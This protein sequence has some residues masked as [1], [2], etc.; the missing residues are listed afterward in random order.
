MPNISP[1]TSRAANGLGVAL[2]L[3]TSLSNPV[4]ASIAAGVGL[5]GLVD[6]IGQGRKSA[7]KFTQN[8]GPQDI[9][10]KQ[11]AAISSSNAS[12]EEKAQATEKAW[13]DF[14]QAANQFAAANPKQSTVVQQAIYK[15]P[16]LT[17]TVKT[18]MGGKDPLDPNYTNMAAS[19][20]ATGA[21]G[22]NPGPSFG[23]T[24]LNSAISAGEV[25]ATDYLRDKF[26]GPSQAGTDLPSQGGVAGG[27]PGTGAGGGVVAG[28]NK[29]L[30]PS[31]TAGNLFRNLVVP[32]LIGGGLNLAG[33]LIGANASSDAAKTQADAAKYA[34]D[35]N[36]KA[37]KD[38]LDFQKQVFDTQQKNLEPWMQAGAGALTSI[39]DL[40]KDPAYQW[41]KQFTAPDPSKTLEN[42]AVK[43]QLDQGRKL[44]ESTAAARGKIFNP[45]TMEA[46]DKYGQGV[47]SEAYG[48][49]Y[50]RA[51]N[52]YQN[53]YQIFQN[54]RAA[55]LNPLQSLAGLGQT[56]TGQSLTSGN[57]AA[58]NSANI[59]MGT[60]ARVGDQLTDAANANASGYVG[61]GNSF[62]NALQNIGNNFM[63]AY[64]IYRSKP[65]A[66]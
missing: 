24:L 25:Y 7:N 63:D 9:I 13:T 14:L 52:E 33:G 17:N 37:G 16:Q 60:A 10:N 58:S 43:F 36:A 45:G 20:I 11:L 2:P 32:N 29:V 42:P 1:F 40:M 62:L 50:N 38:A 57:A 35:L 27:T 47:A 65:A 4:S 64:S 23:K 56:A 19:G 48:D 6:K 28:I 51:A 12:A 18:L 30:N 5:L 53:A 54:E 31:S 15:T 59:G 66:A 55:R 49:V 26:S 22:K 61:R 34:A 21:A 41:N 39:Q 44:I 46:V 8:G 3:L